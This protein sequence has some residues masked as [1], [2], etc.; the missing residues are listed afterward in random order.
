MKTA[1]L[2]ALTGSSSQKPVKVKHLMLLGKPLEVDATLTALRSSGEINSALITKNGVTQWMYW[3]TGVIDPS[4]RGMFVINQKRLIESRIQNP[5]K[6]ADKVKPKTSEVTGAVCPGTGNPITAITPESIPEKEIAMTNT[7]QTNVFGRWEIYN[8][9]V[10]QPGIS[11]AD[12]I[13]ATQA[14][15][16]DVEPKKISKTI[17]NMWRMAK[18]IRFDGEGKDRLYYANEIKKPAAAPVKTASL[19]VKNQEA[20]PTPQ[21]VLPVVTNQ[22]PDDLPACTQPPLIA[23]KSFSLMLSD[24][25]NL[26]ISLG[27]EVFRLDPNQLARL[28]NF[29]GRVLPD[30][31]RA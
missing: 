5:L 2:N 31:V 18:Q 8:L 13:R 7:A 25:N 6:R 20:M 4:V 11:H 21:S 19:P 23:D 10:A 28:D 9:V 29:L 3:L 14:Q 17:D 22:G 30:G 16:P 24:E 1:I 26:F 12:L 15:F 27:D